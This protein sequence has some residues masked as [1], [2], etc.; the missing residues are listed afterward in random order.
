MST[1]SS[2]GCRRY[3]SH[4][5]RATPSRRSRSDSGCGRQLDL[6]GDRVDHEVDEHGLARNVGVDRHRAEVEAIGDASHRHRL[7]S[8][9]IGDLDRRP[10]RRRR[11]SSAGAAR[12]SGAAALRAASL[13]PPE[14]RDRDRRV[15]LLSAI[16]RSFRVHRMVMSVVHRTLYETKEI[17]CLNYSLIAEGLRKSYGATTALDGFDLRV[18]SGRIHALLGPNGAG[19]TTAVRVLTTLTRAD[20]GTA[21]RRRHRRHGPSRASPR[22]DRDDRAEPRGRRDPRRPREPRHVRAPRRAPDPRRPGPRRRTAR[23]LRPHRGGRTGRSADS[24]AACVAASTSPP[25]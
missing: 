22:P 24:R 13:V 2:Q 6:A 10:S 7:E 9:G 18:E 16:A 14:Q 5:R 12:G 20:G 11:R 23:D 15:A 8:L 17:G 25:A 1:C 4:C 3:S 21:I 19:K